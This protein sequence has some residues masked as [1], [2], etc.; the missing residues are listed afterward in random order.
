MQ[1]IPLGALR[2]VWGL[3]DNRTIIVDLFFDNAVSNVV[4]VFSKDPAFEASKVGITQ[5]FL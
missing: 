4:E 3:N 1:R 2:V 5:D